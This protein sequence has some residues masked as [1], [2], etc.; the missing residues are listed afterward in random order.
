[1]GPLDASTCLGESDANN[2]ADLD[3]L[4]NICEYPL[5]RAFAP[6]MISAW[7]DGY[8][9][10]NIGGERYWLAQPANAYGANVVLVYL[11]AYYEDLGTWPTP[12][13]PHADF[14]AGDSEA[15]ALYVRYIE[16]TDHWVLV[17]ASYSVHTNYVEYWSVGGFPL[18]YTVEGLEY[19]SRIGGRPISWVA[20]FKH[21]NYSSQYNCNAG[22]AFGFDFCNNL[23]NSNVWDFE[24]YESHNIGSWHTRLKDCVHAEFL[25]DTSETE[26]LW[27]TEGKWFGWIGWTVGYDPNDGSDPVGKRMEHWGLTEQ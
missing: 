9:A 3:G 22:G 13:G 17:H 11:P 15:I 6:R 27:Q 20:G 21:G 1:M 25:G 19:A 7:S 12:S 24:V 18:N 4:L 5:T 8:H 2:D 26:C 23:A 14:H 16:E 10:E